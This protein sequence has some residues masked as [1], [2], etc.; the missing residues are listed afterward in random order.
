MRG[1]AMM[2]LMIVII[3]ISILTALVYPQGVTM[4]QFRE[5]RHS[6]VYP[7]IVWPS[8]EF[9]RTTSRGYPGEPSRSLGSDM[10]KS[11]S[12][13]FRAVRCIKGSDNK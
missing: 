13:I 4:L 6:V 7:N 2:E 12:G 9:H 8:S 10:I 1:I 11:K 3:I 5:Q